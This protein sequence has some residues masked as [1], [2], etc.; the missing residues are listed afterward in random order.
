MIIRG[1]IGA[2]FVGPHGHQQEGGVWLV[3]TIAELH[4][5]FDVDLELMLEKEA[6]HLARA[7]GGVLVCPL[8]DPCFNLFFLHVLVEVHVRWAN[9]YGQAA[10][11]VEPGSELL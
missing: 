8:V 10:L 3:T 1:V 7:V 11:V 6:Q 5:V 9:G 2:F 4:G